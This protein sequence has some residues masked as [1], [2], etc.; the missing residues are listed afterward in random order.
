MKLVELQTIQQELHRAKGLRHRSNCLC[1]E[2][3]GEGGVWGMWVDRGKRQTFLKYQAE[4]GQSKTIAKAFGTC[5]IDRY[6]RGGIMFS[7]SFAISHT[8]IC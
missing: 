6:K 7:R 5:Q 3:M 4:M 8:L 2:G 1:L